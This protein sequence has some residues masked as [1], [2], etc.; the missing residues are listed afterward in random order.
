M[1]LDARSMHTIGQFLDKNEVP[2][3]DRTVLCVIEG[4]HY[5]LDE[6]GCSRFVEDSFEMGWTKCVPPTCL[7]GL[8]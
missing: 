2:I 7:Q 6:R 8:F 3:E 4:V 5:R 1:K